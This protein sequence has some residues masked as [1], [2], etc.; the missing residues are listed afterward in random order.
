MLLLSTKRRRTI[1]PSYQI[2]FVGGGELNWPPLQIICIDDHQ[3]WIG[4][5]AYWRT[6]WVLRFLLAGGRSLGEHC[7]QAGR[8]QRN[9][10][11]QLGDQCMCDLHQQTNA[12]RLPVA[13]PP[14]QYLCTEIMTPWRCQDK[15][16]SSC[17][18]PFA[19]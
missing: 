7:R 10:G 17:R 9:L 2:E 1:M 4:P 18:A 15:R 19:W 3:A 6:I 14:D 16:V 13:N 11:S 8:H 12:L 5:P